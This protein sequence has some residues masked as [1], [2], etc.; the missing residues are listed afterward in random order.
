M[1][2]ED[3]G[4]LIKEYS[5]VYPQ[6]FRE[7]EGIR[8]KPKDKYLLNLIEDP[9]HHKCNGKLLPKT[10]TNGEGKEVQLCSK[11]YKWIEVKNPKTVSR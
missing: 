10:E 6:I 1:D 11:C 7:L 3:F 9:Y 4:T 8:K 5:D 2:R